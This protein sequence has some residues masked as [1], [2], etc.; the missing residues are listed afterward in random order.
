MS[1]TNCLRTPKKTKGSL[2][3]KG[4]IGIIVFFGGFT[5]IV[6]LENLEVR[7]S[8]GP[9]AVCVGIGFMPTRRFMGRMK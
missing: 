6:E 4:N 7:G 3:D 2:P 9:W 8:E 5:Q 1:S